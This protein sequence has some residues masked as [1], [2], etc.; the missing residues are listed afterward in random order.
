MFDKKNARLVKKGKNPVSM[1]EFLEKQE[2][3]LRLTE[4]MKWLYIATPVVI[5]AFFAYTAGFES[6]S[7]FVLGVGIMFVVEAVFMYGIWKIAMAGVRGKRAW[8]EK[9]RSELEQ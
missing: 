9:K 8:I 7:D 6:I 4:K 3:D 1:E 5:S 2:K